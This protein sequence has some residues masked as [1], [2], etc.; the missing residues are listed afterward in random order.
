MN[1]TSVPK[2]IAP[3]VKRKPPA[4]TIAAIVT[5]PIN[6]ATAEKADSYRTPDIC[7]VRCSAS[8]TENSCATSGSRRNSCT[9]RIP[10]TTS[11]S[12][13]FSRATAV[14]MAR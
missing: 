14:R 1:A 4:Q 10:E 7:A 6:S 12:E 5:E 11:W 13:A 9:I 3:P 2:V 8:R